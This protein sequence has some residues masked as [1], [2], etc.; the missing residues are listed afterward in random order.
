M[1]GGGT[2]YYTNHLQSAQPPWLL[3]S[4]CREGEG[5]KKTPETD[6]IFERV[7]AINTAADES[8]QSS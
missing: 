4:Q 7:W 8:D 5:S 2:S 3:G 6:A 1:G